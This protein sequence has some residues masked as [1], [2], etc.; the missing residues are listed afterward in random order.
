MTHLQARLEPAL[1]GRYSLR[2]ELGE[3]GMAIV[4]LA[5]DLRHDREVALKVLRPEVSAEIGAERFLLEIKLA[6]GLTH[7]HILPVF[8][9]GEAD[10]LLFYVM[11]S[12]EGRSLRERLDRERQLSLAEAL[13]ITREVASA[14]DY[15]HRHN[16]VHRDIKPENILLHDGAAMV[17]DFGIGKVLSAGGRSLTQT[18]LAIGTP[19]YMSP[20]QSA[21]ELSTDGRSDLYSL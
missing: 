19:A 2:R 4:F 15:A 18:G 12:M 16:V 14:L 17:A 1:A 20:E 11:P 7:P 21:G 8:D 10:G 5:H 6:A 13:R 9:S 3:G